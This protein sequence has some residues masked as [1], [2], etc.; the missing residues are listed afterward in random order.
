MKVYYQS[1]YLFSWG[2][3]ISLEQAMIE[4]AAILKKNIVATEIKLEAENTE[5]RS[6]LIR[7]QIYADK[8][9]HSLLG[10]TADAA[11]VLVLFACADAV[12]LASAATFA[13][14][15]Q[16]RLDALTQL[17]GS[18]EGAGKLVQKAADLLADVQSGT[19]VMPFLVKPGNAAGVFDDVATR[20][21][22]AAK[23]LAPATN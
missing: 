8:D 18:P 22:A 20:A 15:K 7:Q 4:C 21:T 1:N 3:P 11:Q 13:A 16:A 9:I 6:Y 14:Y 12:A 2:G 5:E 10:T 19:V 23:V 17:S